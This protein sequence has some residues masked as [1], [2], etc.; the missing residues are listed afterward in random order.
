[1]A[2]PDAE[3]PA[4]AKRPIAA[5][6]EQDV[7]PNISNADPAGP[8][9]VVPAPHAPRSHGGL[10]N[11]LLCRVDGCSRHLG[12]EKAYFQRYRCCMSH[13]KQPS[14]HVGGA[15]QRWCQQCCCFHELHYFDGDRRN[16]RERLA[17]H[18][19]RRSK[20]N[21]ARPVDHSVGANRELRCRD[22]DGAPKAPGGVTS[23]S[24]LSRKR[25][26]DSLAE[27][28]D[29]SQ[30]RSHAFDGL[31]RPVHALQHP[32]VYPSA[33]FALG[34]RD[35]ETHASAHSPAELAGPSAWDVHL[36]APVLGALLQQQQQQWG[37]MGLGQHPAWP[38]RA[39]AGAQWAAQSAAAVGAAPRAGERHPGVAPRAARSS[40]AR[41]GRDR[42]SAPG[43]SSNPGGMDGLNALLAAAEVDDVQA[44]V[45]A[46]PG[47]AAAREPQLAVQWAL[48]DALLSAPAGPAVCIEPQLAAAYSQKLMELLIRQHVLGMGL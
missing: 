6:N 11:R 14:V 18:N 32:R 36:G 21:S 9:P 16:C 5:Q 48:P 26:A 2:L 15:I 35:W 12:R 13:S 47:L 30:E 43:L 24:Q 19:E 22:A 1:M 46:E 44:G 10:K 41:R 23:S 17:Q 38:V 4:A 8:A 28:D 29:S 34:A 40:W 37:Q 25:R 31:A 39:A 45:K 7:R 3:L 42:A 20:R 33:A 27:S